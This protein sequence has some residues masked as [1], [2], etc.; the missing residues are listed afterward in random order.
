M[1]KIFLY[2]CLLTYGFP[3]DLSVIIDPDTIY[4]GSVVKI[5]IKFESVGKKYYFYCLILIYISSYFV[6]LLLLPYVS[7]FQNLK[8]NLFDIKIISFDF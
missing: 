7:D 5:I 6:L 3:S 8:H 2:I 1:H 4:V